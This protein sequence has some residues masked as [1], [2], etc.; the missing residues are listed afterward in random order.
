VI[1]RA[2]KLEEEGKQR[3]VCWSILYL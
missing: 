1:D 3:E 2:I